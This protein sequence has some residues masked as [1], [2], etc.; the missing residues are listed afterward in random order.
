MPRNPKLTRPFSSVLQPDAKIMKDYATFM[1]AHLVNDTSAL[2]VM[3]FMRYYNLYSADVY[4]ETTFADLKTVFNPYKY[5][6][7]TELSVNATGG[8]E[9]TKW[10]TTGRVSIENPAIM[11]DNKTVYVAD[12]ANFG[13]LT[14]FVMDTPQ[15]MS[16]GTL[17]AAKWAQGAAATAVSRTYGDIEWAIT[18]IELGKAAQD[19]L[20]AMVDD[21]TFETIFEEGDAPVDGV[22]AEGYTYVK[23]GWGIIHEECLKVLDETAAAFFETRRYA[24]YMGATVETQ[25]MEGMAIVPETNKF[26]VAMS[27]ISNGMDETVLPVGD[28]LL[29]PNKCGCVF[30]FDM[31]ETYSLTTARAF[32]CGEEQEADVDKNECSTA[33][34]ASPDNLF[35][36]G[37]VAGGPNQLLIAEDTS[38]HRNDYLWAYDFE[39]ETMTRLMTTVYGSQV[40]GPAFY[41][42]GKGCYLL[43]AVVP[44]PYKKSDQDLLGAGTLG[45]AGT[46]GYIGPLGSRDEL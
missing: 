11:P 13:V 5:G 18:W 31:D 12:D 21:L 35:Y 37:H 45:L 33:S 7:V 25:A 9:V 38:Y 22:C 39:T 20:L 29:A 43:M 17:Y 3:L 26:Y 40:T 14:K 10:Y 46:V 41:E 42:D 30:E 28:I 8:T 2:N 44:H 16:S 27:K 32:I 34:I 15:D 36:M 19:D 6:H 4:D 1:A 24:A 23:A